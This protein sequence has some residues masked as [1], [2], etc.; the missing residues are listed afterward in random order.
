MIVESE[1]F[2]TGEETAEINAFAVD[3]K[4]KKKNAEKAVDDEDVGLEKLFDE[5]K[6]SEENRKAKV[7]ELLNFDNEVS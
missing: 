7:E 3:E 2:V 1:G 5:A 4:D 6:E